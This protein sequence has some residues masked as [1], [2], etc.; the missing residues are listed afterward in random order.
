MGIGLGPWLAGG[1]ALAG[2]EAAPSEAEPTT[3]PAAEAVQLTWEAPAACGDEAAVRRGLAA[4]LREDTAVEAGTGV[5]AEAVVEE[6][7]GVFRLR[8]RTETSSGVTT[9]ETTAEDCSVLVEA[10]ALIVAIA[11]DPSAVVARS[12][13][14]PEPPEPAEPEPIEPEPVEPEPIE[15]EPSETEPSPASERPEGV[16]LVGAG[17]AEPGPPLPVRFG[18]R[19]SGGVD[20]GVLPAVAGGVRLTGAVLGR[21]WRAELRGDAWLPRTALA[22]DQLGARISLWSVGA[23]GCGVPG[24]ARV[25]L[26]FPLCGGVEAGAMRGDPVGDRVDGGVTVREP[27]VA[28]GASAGLAW[29]PRRFIALVAQAE[30]TVPLRRAGFRVG[31]IE[32]HRAGPVGGRG[33]VGLEARFP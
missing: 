6:V 3:S 15:P 28:A 1:L 17:D 13:E 25:G 26:E 18:M 14:V 33:L 23:R 32:L 22:E 31:E 11:V 24:V 8:L 4:Y 27:W 20:V 29:S 21:G 2:P 7:D 16:D 30:L 19:V 12:D 10:T 5:R 9:R